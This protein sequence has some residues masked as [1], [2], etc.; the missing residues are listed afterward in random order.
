MLVIFTSVAHAERVYLSQNKNSNVYYD[1]TEL[2]DLCTQNVRSAF[3]WGFELAKFKLNIYSEIKS[4][5]VGVD[6]TKKQ[7]GCTP[8][9][10][11][12]SPTKYIISEVMF[13]RRSQT[14][15][16]DQVYLYDKNFNLITSHMTVAQ[17][18]AGL[19]KQVV[20]AYERITEQLVKQALSPK[21]YKAWVQRRNEAQTRAKKEAQENQLNERISPDQVQEEKVQPDNI[22]P[23]IDNDKPTEDQLKAEHS[24]QNSETDSQKPDDN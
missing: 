16:E 3:T 9:Y 5:K 8:Q 6:V 11:R 4:T 14:G 12:I 22:Q 18:P 20:A 21:E 7:T 23:H 10:A 15:F 17:V 19:S 2:R 1:R 24:D 13:D